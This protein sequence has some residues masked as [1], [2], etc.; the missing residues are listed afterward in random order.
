MKNVAPSK[1]TAKL[2]VTPYALPGLHFTKRYFAVRINNC[3]QKTKPNKLRG[4]LLS[5]GDF[6]G[7]PVFPLRVS[8]TWKSS[9]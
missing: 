8:L 9:L 3:I 5:C 2:P 1:M 6:N 7:L 4:V